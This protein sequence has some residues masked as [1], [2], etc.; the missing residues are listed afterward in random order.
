MAT[1]TRDGSYQQLIV[2]RTS[3]VDPRHVEAWL[4]VEYPTLDGLSRA[5]LIEEID[6]AIECAREA[7]AEQ[8]EA[9]AASF[10]L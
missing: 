4:R 3:D 6:I 1:T 10:G 9:L 5:Q 2:E 7:G 8:S